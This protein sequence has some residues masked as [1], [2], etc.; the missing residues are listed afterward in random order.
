M[1]TATDRDGTTHLRPLLGLPKAALVDLC[2]ANGWPFV[3][4]PSNADDRFA[5]TR[6]RKLMPT[7]AAEGLTP[8]RLGRLAVRAARVEDALDL[9]AREAVA[10]AALG[11]GSP[12]KF[13]AETLLDEPFEIASRALAL[14]LAS[15]LR[16]AEPG[17]LDRLEAC[18][19]RLCAALRGGRPLRFT[20]RGAVLSLDRRGE[21][22]VEPEPVRRRGTARSA[23]GAA[24]SPHSLGKGGGHA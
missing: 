9:K 11:D 4:D 23:R 7:L 3:Q 1:R 5:R 10:R 21:L 24:A 12:G 17:R 13:R 18:T 8:E 20:L 14:A 15:R 6:W 19:A 22:T 2:H 16:G